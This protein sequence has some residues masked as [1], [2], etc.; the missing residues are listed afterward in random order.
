VKEERD[1]L[2]AAPGRKS[3]GKTQA[4]RSK[5]GVQVNIED[6]M[7]DLASAGMGLMGDDQ[8]AAADFA[9]ACQR[10]DE[11]PR[12]QQRVR[13]INDLVDAEDAIYAQAVAAIGRGDL[14]AAV[15]LLRA[16]AEAGIGDSAWMLA[17]VLEKLGR[18][19]E[20]L[21]W[22][23]RAAIDGDPRADDKVAMLRHAR[24]EQQP[25]VGSPD[26]DAPGG[27]D[28]AATA[29]RDVIAVVECKTHTPAGESIAAHRFTEQR[30][31]DA[32][33]RLLR[34]PWTPGA[35][36]SSFSGRDVSK[37]LALPPSVFWSGE[38]CEVIEILDCCFASPDA[39]VVSR[40]TPQVVEILDCSDDFRVPAAGSF[41][42]ETPTRVMR[43]L[44]AQSLH[45]VGTVDPAC[46]S[47]AFL[48]QAFQVMATARP[49]AGP[50]T[51]RVR[52][53]AAAREAAAADIMLPMSS[54]PMVTP[55]ATLDE[56]LEMV[57]EHGGT[58]LPVADGADVVGVITLTDLAQ[59]MHQARGLPSI[60][61]VE[62]LMRPAVTVPAGT[63]TTDVMTAAAGSPAGL[64]LVT[65]PDGTPSGY[66][67]RE[68][69]LAQ[70]PSNRE[71]SAHSTSGLLLPSPLETVAK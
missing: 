63:P 5:G 64:L 11:D 65:G 16:T 14:E 25:R 70:P 62:T 6:L 50:G 68:S 34:E 13:D 52:R 55:E 66:L 8:R 48:T 15:P 56:A 42:R 40:W 44:F 17:G 30:L 35:G 2:P 1:F 20:A 41:R 28:T 19:Q 4:V 43:H 27:T 38:P 31:A 71:R 36:F 51:F 61:R 21:L 18:H 29:P 54:A 26:G 47:G 24:Q 45:A 3:P 22:Y 37:L 7:R 23:R 33:L 32:Y 67:T 53:R 12:E 39:S 60:Q 69:L 46:G 49:Y 58:A 10:A 59:A 9:E 57:L